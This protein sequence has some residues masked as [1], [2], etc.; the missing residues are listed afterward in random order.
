MKQHGFTLIELM[1][2]IAII[3]ILAAIALPVY[4]KY[5]QKAADYSCM[6]ETKAY[7]NMVFAALVDP[8]RSVELPLAPNY[9]SC[10]AI[11]DAS[12]WRGIDNDHHVIQGTI[13]RGAHT[14]VSCDLLNGT[15]C[16]LVK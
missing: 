12:S 8:N 9:K 2:T 15:T 5:L 7:T 13:R 6:H 11:T 16:S 4:N 1:I 14:F 3:A 10:D